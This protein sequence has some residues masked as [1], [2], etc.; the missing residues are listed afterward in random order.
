[1][2]TPAQVNGAGNCASLQLENCDQLSNASLKQSTFVAVFS[3]S[4]LCMNMTGWSAAQLCLLHFATC[5]SKRTLRFKSGLT[6][7]SV[8]LRINQS[9]RIWPVVLSLG[10]TLS[11]GFLLLVDQYNTSWGNLCWEDLFA[12]C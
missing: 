10:P 4:Q 9:P 12:Y 5:L 6:G 11:D 8:C 3:T 2:D 1:M 7:S